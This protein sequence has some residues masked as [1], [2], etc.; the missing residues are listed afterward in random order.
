M[1]SCQ[2]LLNEGAIIYSP[3]NR[4]IAYK[5]EVAFDIIV[6][7]ESRHLQQAHGILEILP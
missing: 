5:L 7:H 1:S 3:A 4:R 2:D 6:A